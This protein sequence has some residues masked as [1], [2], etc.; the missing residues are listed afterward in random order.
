[1]TEFAS[2][3]YFYW[4]FYLQFLIFKEI[5]NN[6]SESES[7]GNQKDNKVFSEDVKFLANLLIEIITENNSKCLTID[8]LIEF[9]NCILK[10]YNLKE[11]SV[12]NK[13]NNFFKN[14]KYIF[15]I[16]L[17]Q[18]ISK[19]YRKNT[20]FGMNNST[21]NL[22]LNYNMMEMNKNPMGFSNS[23]THPNLFL[24][25]NT[26]MHHSIGNLNIPKLNVNSNLNHS[27]I[28][29]HQYF[30]FFQNNNTNYNN[31]SFVP[32]D[33]YPIYLDNHSNKINF[34]HP[35]GNNINHYINPNL[36]NLFGSLGSNSSGS[37]NQSIN[38]VNYFNEFNLVN[39]NPY[40]QHMINNNSINK[41]NMSNLNPPYLNYELIKNINDS[42]ILNNNNSFYQIKEN[43]VINETENF[44]NELGS[45]VKKITNSAI[46]HKGVY[47]PILENKE[48]NQSKLNS[49]NFTSKNVNNLGSNVIFSVDNFLNDKQEQKPNLQA[50]IDN[51]TR[52]K[53]FNCE[54]DAVIVMHEIN[55]IP[56]RFD[57][58]FERKI[59]KEYEQL[60][61]VKINKQTN[62]PDRNIEGNKADKVFDKIKTNTPQSVDYMTKQ[63]NSKETEENQL[64]LSKKR[65]R[66]EPNEKKAEY[67]EE[68]N[69]SIS[70]SNTDYKIHKT[71]KQPKIRKIKRN[72]NFNFQDNY[73]DINYTNNNNQKSSLLTYNNLDKKDLEMIYSIDNPRRKKSKKKTI[74]EGGDKNLLHSE[75]EQEK[76]SK[77]LK[78]VP[79]FDE[80][81]NETLK[82][83]SHEFMN[84]NF[85]EMY[86]AEN[87]FLYIKLI[88]ERRETKLGSL[89]KQIHTIEINSE[90]VNKPHFDD[91]FKMVWDC[92]RLKTEEGILFK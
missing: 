4:L 69:D 61:D 86:N 66:T 68:D 18:A 7:C 59:L 15:V 67:L 38:G 83:K 32:N 35:N 2:K 85:P 5:P 63:I 54:N 12:E 22:P 52:V 43:K 48:I 28:N 36:S 20:N 60:E 77:F 26:P 25:I 65:I 46:F 23:H 19:E 84:R 91:Y 37:L 24:N 57:I 81:L 45:N 6:N 64:N 1:M 75:K 82:K 21:A 53:K 50:V 34:T 76:L 71:D 90:T 88:E 70:I 42:M 17:N 41:S 49:S 9:V 14:S 31:F 78:Y 74:N 10:K 56:I 72:E 13:H 29:Y 30:Q 80:D 8:N 55:N 58:V 11:I 44:N 33:N 92:K 62:S 16:L 79:I 27:Q 47:N 87:F 73:N 51:S 3:N 40:Y 89:Q 39:K